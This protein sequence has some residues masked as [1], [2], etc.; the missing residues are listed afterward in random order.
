MGSPWWSSS[1]GSTECQGPG[2]SWALLAAMVVRALPAIWA[3][4]LLQ[5]KRNGE[6]G[7]DGK[8]DVM[9]H[10]RSRCLAAQAVIGYGW[11]SHCY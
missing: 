6:L 4:L 8:G 11:A 5:G 3:A 9:S 1:K 7:S 2:K 10:I